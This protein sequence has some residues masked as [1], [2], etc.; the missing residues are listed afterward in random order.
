MRNISL[1]VISFSFLNNCHAQLS[2]D[3][4][5]DKNDKVAIGL[6][7]DGNPVAGSARL[8]DKNNSIRIQNEKKSGNYLVIFRN[9]KSNKNPF[10][11]AFGKG[12][13]GVETVPFINGTAELKFDKD[14][15]NLPG[16][17][18]FSLPCD[19]EVRNEKNIS[20]KSFTIPGS[21][22]S[23]SVKEATADVISFTGVPYYDASNLNSDKISEQ[24]FLKILSFYAGSDTLM[25]KDSIEKYYSQNPFLRDIVKRNDF[26]TTSLVSTGGALSGF[27]LSSIGGLSV[28]NFA[29]GL[30]KF[31]VKRFKEELTITFFQKFKEEVGKSDELRT[32][33]PESYKVLLAIDKD[34]YQFSA[35]LVTLRESFIK[36]LTNL[37]VN[38]KKFTRLD[39]YERYFADPAHL[40]IRTLIYTGL[41]LVDEYAKG[42]HAGKVLA[43][44]NINDLQFSDTVLQHNVRSSVA[45][46]K[47]ISESFRSLA[48]EH[49]WVPSDSAEAFLGDNTTRNIYFGLIFQKYGNISFCKS[50]RD[51]VR[52]DTIL[53]N[54]GR[55]S[56]SLAEYK[57]FVETFIDHAQ[58]ITEYVTELKAKRKED[59]D[60]NDYYK[61]CNSSLDLFQHAFTFINL[62]GI[63]LGP[64]VKE[65]LRLQSDRWLFVARS[66]GEMYVDTRTKNYS[67]AILNVSGIIDT[68]LVS[69]HNSI[70]NPANAILKY[71]TFASAVATAQN[72]DD[73]EKAIESVALPSG[74]SRIK[75]ESVSNI[76]LNGYVGGFIGGEYLPALKEKQNAFS[77][78]LSAPVG[79]AFSFGKHRFLDGK[80]PGGK[81]WTIF[82][83]LIDV[84]ALASFRLQNDSSKVASE[85]LLKNI[86]APGLFLYLG[87]GKCPVSVGIG[88]QIGPQLR[89]IPVKNPENINIDK[90]YYVRYGLSVAVDIPI[91]NFHTRSDK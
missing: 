15:Q 8:G 25:G 32:L 7:Q 5:I 69:A 23:S 87:L 3:I 26:K 33:F 44:F 91:L 16:G 42:V 55:I 82:V 60:Y 41:Y 43:Q 79:I 48:S 38:F 18:T 84:G 80:N 22:V 6:K 89:D 52:L 65:N 4:S 36:D 19:I 68:I 61:L 78:G 62:P 58:E 85:V 71:G 35:Y 64:G 63:A 1:L 54:A 14:N 47:M 83:P 9:S 86:V 13:P 70:S 37:Y 56:D 10:V 90:N 30:A 11:L 17:I 59:I 34:I 39:K 2:I 67:S 50:T 40:A 12:S 29:D 51:S 53:E 77:I 49:Y 21:A 81:S 28:T 73:V 57:Q 74:S 72:S 46:V 88:A 20:L 31:L 27:S 75:R 45:V 66:A 76:S 24:E